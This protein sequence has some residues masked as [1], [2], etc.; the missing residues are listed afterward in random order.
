MDGGDLP[1][2]QFSQNWFADDIHDTFTLWWG[3]GER[4]NDSA[5]LGGAFRLRPGD[6]ESF[7]WV[8]TTGFFKDTPLVAYF[9]LKV[10]DNTSAS[11]VARISVK[12]GGTEYGPLVLKGTDFAAS[13]TYQEF[14]I[15]FTFHDNPDDVFLFF[16]FWRSG[17]VDFYVDGVYIFTAPQSV[18]SPLTWTVPGGNYRG[19]GIWLRY[20]DDAGDF[21]PVE[22]ADLDPEHISVLPA[23]LRF[24]AEYGAPPPVSQ[25]LTIEQEGCDPFT[26]TVTDDATWLHAQPEGETVQ[27]SVDTADLITGTYQAAIT[28]EAET[29]ILGSP[30]QVPV[31][32]TVADH[33]YQIYLP[34]IVKE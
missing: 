21:S 16:N 13:N 31:T 25:T 14:P 24:L 8:W 20:T 1:Y 17:Q 3:N 29:G 4:V 9:R 12:G 15:A 11:E 26:W 28:I 2:V 34:L 5:A 23:S 7:A 18:Q 33:I 6:G 10:N 27:A 30:V 19:G 32:L 22:E